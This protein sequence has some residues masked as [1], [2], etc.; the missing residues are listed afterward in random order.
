MR[1][2]I[3]EDEPLV[4]QRLER[5][6]RQ[7]LGTRLTDVRVAPGF[8]AGEAFLSEHAVDLLLLD[9]NLDGRDGMALLQTAVAGS[10]HTVIVSANIDQALRAFE[11]GVVDFVPKPFTLERLARALERAA[12]PGGAPAGA[13]RYLAV[14]KH[15]RIEAIPL[16]AVAYVQGAGNYA[17]LVLRD[18]RR[19]LHDKSLDRLAALLPGEFTRIHKSYLVRFGDVVALHAFEGSHYEAELRGGARLPVGRTRYKEL[20]TRLN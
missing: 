16:E 4:A 7:I 17:E 15:G 14:K 5:F 19:E 12:G 11:Y 20:R 8:D 18:G 2:L 13:M 1:V 6:C 10:F 3:V 9:L